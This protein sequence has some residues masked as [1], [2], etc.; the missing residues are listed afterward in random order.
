MLPLVM[1]PAIDKPTHFRLIGEIISPMNSVRFAPEVANC[2]K[3][4]QLCKGKDRGIH[5]G[6]NTAP[7]VT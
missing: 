6:G 5:T 1:A 2:V 4:W 3:Y 7:Y